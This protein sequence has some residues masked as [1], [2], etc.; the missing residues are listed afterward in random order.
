MKRR[1][2][3][4]FV[5][6]IKRSK[7]VQSSAETR[8][9]RGKRD[10]RMIPAGLRAPA[11]SLNGTPPGVSPAV[12]AAK[13]AADRIFTRHSSDAS[14]PVPDSSNSN[15][16]HFIPQVGA[17]KPLDVAVQKVAPG[18]MSASGMQSD[19]PTEKPR[20][21][22]ILQSLASENFVEALLRQKAEELTIRLRLPRTQPARTASPNEAHRTIRRDGTPVSGQ[23]TPVDAPT[24]SAKPSAELPNCEISMDGRRKLTEPATTGRA[25]PPKML[26]P[27]RKTS[28]KKDTNRRRKGD[29]K[30]TSNA[31][32]RAK[33]KAR[34]SSAR[35]SSEK[36]ASARA[37]SGKKLSY[38]GQ[39]AEKAARKTATPRKNVTKRAVISNKVRVRKMHRIKTASR[40]TASRKPAS[41]KRR[42]SS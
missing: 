24:P 25:R 39:F 32:A 33:A 41:S 5:V 6:E 23:K 9:A 3:M 11:T 27:S 20:T 4:S 42:R 36:G 22:R 37:S 17:T 31:R 2:P 12:E 16:R 35:K 40:K 14:I 38:R 26:E 28:R 18:N 30:T 8:G 34:R 1:G 10:V 13:V 7:V 15:E 19:A 29:A 21:G